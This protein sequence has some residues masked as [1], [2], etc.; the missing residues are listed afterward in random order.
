LNRPKFVIDIDS[1]IHAQTF[2]SQVVQQNRTPYRSRG[3]T[4]AAIISSHVAELAMP[5]RIVSEW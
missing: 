2:R 3:R 4:I 5:H 1:L